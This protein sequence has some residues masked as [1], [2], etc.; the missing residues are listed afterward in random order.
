MTRKV[1]TLAVAATVT[2]CAPGAS[3]DAP[4]LPGQPAPGQ[5]DILVDVENDR[6][7]Q[8]K[9]FATRANMRFLVGEVGGRQQATFRLPPMILRGEGELRLVAEP[10]GSTQF[11]ESEP[12]V[13][14][15]ARLVKWRLRR[16]GN[17]QHWIQ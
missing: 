3:R 1:L 13:L 12:I 2:A 9:I 4:E 10:R 17:E 14:T 8:L 15:D 7:V 11:Q 6:P 16:G 5:A